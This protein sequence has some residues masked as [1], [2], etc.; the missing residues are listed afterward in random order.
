MS[1]SCR[2]FLFV[3]TFAVLTFA[4]SSAY[5]QSDCD[6]VC[7]PY[8]S[9]CSDY[10]DRCLWYTVDGCGEYTASTCGGRFGYGPCLDDN[11]TPNWV[12]TSR[13]NVGTYDGRSLNGCTHHRVDEVTITDYNQCNVNSN[14]WS[15]T[16]CSDYIDDTK[17]GCCYLSCCEG[18]GENGT[19]LECNGVHSC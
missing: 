5:A 4:G 12:E 10:C 7:D 15:Y 9:Y 1:R 11:C 3:F 19:L 13:V 16:Y 2:S 18:Y 14:Y 6:E 8:F 17:D